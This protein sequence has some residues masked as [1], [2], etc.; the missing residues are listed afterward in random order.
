MKFHHLKIVSTVLLFIPPQYAMG[1]I[2]C[3]QCSTHGSVGLW[4]L[5]SFLVLPWVAFGFFNFAH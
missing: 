1:I 5:R 3:H 4:K 2:P